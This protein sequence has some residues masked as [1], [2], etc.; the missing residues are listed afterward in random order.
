MCQLCGR[1]IHAVNLSSF[2]ENLFFQTFKREIYSSNMHSDYRGYLIS[3]YLQNC[4]ITISLQ[5]SEEG[6]MVLFNYPHAIY[7]YYIQ[8]IINQKCVKR[9]KER[10][11]R[12]EMCIIMLNSKSKPFISTNKKLLNCL[13]TRYFK[14]HGI[15]LSNCI[16]LP[17]LMQYSINLLSQ[18]L[19]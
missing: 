17:M 15:L 7:I 19:P 10:K 1:Y 6:Q 2:M 11:K 12:K 13:Q 18:F 16:Y 9:K 5:S 4:F 8:L 3:I 14:V